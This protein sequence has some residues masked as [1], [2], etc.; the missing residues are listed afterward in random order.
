[1][2]SIDRV[3]LRDMFPPPGDL[4]VQKVLT[5]LD[6]HCLYFLSL[7]PFLLIAT[8]GNNGAD[9]SPRGDP[10]GFVKAIDRQTI[11]IPDRPGNNRLDTME[12]ILDNARVGC[13]FLVP[14]L[15]EILR[16]NGEADLV[17]GPELEQLAFQGKTPP[18]AIR[19]RV[20]EALFHCAKAVIR[21]K[22]WSPATFARREDF[23][24]LGAVLADQIAGLDKDEMIEW[25]RVGDQ[26]TLY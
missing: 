1:M 8:Q 12:N 6:K 4:V 13:L 9:V 18:V 25:I 23:P 16:I 26:R 7:S 22:I 17:V 10:A 24:P 19:I 14:G 3:K 2:Q 11:L 5:Q 21:S 20:R 15:G